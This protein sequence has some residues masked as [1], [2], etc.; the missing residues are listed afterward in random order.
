MSG[1][2]LRGALHFNSDS[3][4]RC[5]RLAGTLLREV[6]RGWLTGPGDGGGAGESKCHHS[7]R[8]FCKPLKCEG[9]VEGFYEDPTGEERKVLLRGRECVNTQPVRLTRWNIADVPH[10]SI[11]RRARRKC[12]RAKLGGELDEP[13]V[14]TLRDPQISK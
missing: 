10:E 8:E 14:K 4:P 6:R 2:D 11:W 5:R 7:T 13:A 12:F 3:S 9:S 1:A